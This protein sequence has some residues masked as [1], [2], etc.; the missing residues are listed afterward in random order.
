MLTDVM[1]ESNVKRTNIE[2]TAGQLIDL[3]GYCHSLS[4]TS[5]GLLIDQEPA[6]IV[7]V[8]DRSIS[9]RLAAGSIAASAEA[10]WMSFMDECEPTRAEAGMLMAQNIAR[11]SRERQRSTQSLAILEE[12]GR[13]FELEHFDT[14]CLPQRRLDPFTTKVLVQYFSDALCQPHRRI[15]ELIEEAGLHIH[16]MQGGDPP[17]PSLV[18]SP[19]AAEMSHTNHAPVEEGKKG[20]RTTPADAPSVPSSPHSRF[21]WRPERVTLLREK[22]AEL[23]DSYPTLQVIAK[24]I[25]TDLQW[26]WKTVEYKLGALGLAK[27][28]KAKHAQGGALD[29]QDDRGGTSLLSAPV[30]APNIVQVEGAEEHQELSPERKETEAPAVSAVKESGEIPVIP[31]EEGPRQWQITGIIGRKS[32]GTVRWALSYPFGAFPYAEGNQVSYKQQP[33]LLEEVGS[34]SLR[35]SPLL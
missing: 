12:L 5:E 26:P 11:W 4:I 28:W 24:A 19:D 27:E 29:G 32:G 16:S 10:F 21:E 6:T 35:V 31:L 2:L 22:F 17:V 3:E 13:L 14:L 34:S 7:D 33:Y 30:D 9:I 1:Q 18:P 8:N 15:A 25:G 23:A 20:A